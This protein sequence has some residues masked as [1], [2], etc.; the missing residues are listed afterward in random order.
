M[1]TMMNCK[2]NL[3]CTETIKDF[4]STTFIRDS[5]NVVILTDVF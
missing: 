5:E 3:K 1:M 2:T 4:Y